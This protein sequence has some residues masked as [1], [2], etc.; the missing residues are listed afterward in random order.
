ML[1]LERMSPQTPLRL[2]P[3]LVLTREMKAAGLDSAVRTGRQRGRLTR[4]RR[5]AHVDAATMDSLSDSG[6]YRAHVLA[7][8]STRRNA[9]ATGLSAAALVDLPMIGDWPTEVFVLSSRA[10]GRRRNGVVEVPRRGDEQI[11]TLGGYLATSLLDTLFEVCRSAPFLTAL[12]MVDAAA[13]V[14]RYGGRGPLIQLAEFAALVRERGTAYHG[15]RR[16]R[17]VVDFATTGA[18]TAFETL[19]RV[20][21]HELGFPEPALQHRLYLPRSRRFVFCDFGWPEYRIDGEADG[22][23]KYVNPEYG[24]DISSDQRVKLEKRRENEVRGIRWMPARWEWA[25]AW[26]RDGLLAILREAGLPIVRRPVRL[27]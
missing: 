25:D 1:I 24:P 7:V 9:I 17:A 6:R 11:A 14:D 16:V 2:G 4:L 26:G 10:S 23:G 5:G 12:T 18:D 27:R 20:T 22:W 8:L 3:P 21:I 19:S 13:R 15:S